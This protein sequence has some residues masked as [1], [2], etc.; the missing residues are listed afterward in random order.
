MEFA[1]SS[2]VPELKKLF[3]FVFA[4][5]YMQTIYEFRSVDWWLLCIKGPSSS[6]SWTKKRCAVNWRIPFF[7][8]IETPCLLCL[9]TSVIINDDIHCCRP[10]FLTKCLSTDDSWRVTCL[11]AYIM[12]IIK[13]DVHQPMVRIHLRHWLSSVNGSELCSLQRTEIGNV[14]L[15]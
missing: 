9:W 4:I 14:V 10:C 12:E 15:R 5:S 1:R 7:W 11:R 13:F 8:D 3:I 2:F 6:F